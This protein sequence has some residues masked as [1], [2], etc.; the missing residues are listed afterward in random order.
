MPASL[1]RTSEATWTVPLDVNGHAT[2]SPPTSYPGYRLVGIAHTHPAGAGLDVTL[3]DD[4]FHTHFS[5]ED[6]RFATSFDP[7]IGMYLG[8]VNTQNNFYELQYNQS[9][10]DAQGNSTYTVT[11][12]TPGAGVSTVGC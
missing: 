10:V 6:F 9:G 4:T 12:E 2:P 1:R 5:E 7:P 8:V 3:G 11:G